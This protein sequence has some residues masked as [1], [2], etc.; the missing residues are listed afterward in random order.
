M[1]FPNRNS[2]PFVAF[3]EPNYI[4]KGAKIYIDVC[5]GNFFLFKNGANLIVY[6]G[7]ED[8]SS[9][10]K[11]IKY[12]SELVDYM[13]KENTVLDIQDETENS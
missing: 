1:K 9:E 5:T 12:L 10:E 13:D 11:V 8:L 7:T 6:S 2:T 4:V 3:P